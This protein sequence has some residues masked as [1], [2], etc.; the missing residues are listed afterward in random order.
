MLRKDF[1]I[2]LSQLEN[3]TNLQKQRLADALNENAENSSVR[4]IETHFDEI[5]N[6]PHCENQSF[7]RWGCSHELQ[8]YRCKNCKKTFNALTRSSLSRLR[9][10]K[11]W[12]TY[13]RCLRDGLS[14]KKAAE[15][16]G[17][18]ITTAFRWRHRFMAN[19]LESKDQEMVGIVEADE[20]F[21]T[22][23]SKGN[24]QLTH[25]KARKRGKSAKQR[26]GERVPVLM[27][28]DRSGTVANFVFEQLSKTEVHR[29]LRSIMSEEVVLYS[30][31]NSFYQTFARDEKI[32]HKRVVRN[33]SIYVVDK[34]FHI[35]NLNAYMSRLK[36]WMTRFNGV[37]TKYLSNYLT[38][39]K[40][41]E[42]KDNDDSEEFILRCALA[43]N[44]QQLTQI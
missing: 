27:V 12:I 4:L 9:Y 37:A 24:K 28:R 41:L 42:K 22:E 11:R 1:K 7:L 26:K 16:C 23:S 8:R 31:G 36:N 6:C 13:S 32:L 17:I 25:R 18:D 5:K 40:L 14:V 19:A 21:F 29:C 43:R 35:Q 3:L 34:I 44:N 38:W 2:L 15:I 30:D 39:R 10:K 20:T 33:D